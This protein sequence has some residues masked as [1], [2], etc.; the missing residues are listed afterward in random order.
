MRIADSRTVRVAVAFFL[1]LSTSGAVPGGFA[2][3]AAAGSSQ[4]PPSGV[5]AQL[6][7]RAYDILDKQAHRPGADPS[8]IAFQA[9]RLGFDANRIFAFVRDETRIEPYRGML[10]GARGV[11]AGRAGNALDRSLLLQ[12]L[13]TESGIPCRLMQGKLPDATARQALEQF[14]NAPQ[15]QAP[16]APAGDDSDPGATKL[17][18]QAG[19]PD[20]LVAQ[21]RDRCSTHSATFWRSVSSQADE[22]AAYLSGLLSAAGLK[23][24]KADAVQKDLLDALKTHYWV[25]RQDA[26]GN[27]IDL[28]PLLTTLQ[29]GQTAGQDGKPVPNV[30][31]S[32]HHQLDFSLI[33]RT[34]QGNGAKEEVVLKRTVDAADAPFKPMAFAVQSA[35]S[36]LPA[37]F[38]MTNQQKV[39][40]I[41][42][43]KKFQGVFR[44]GSEMTAG[45]PFDL[46][47]NTYDVQPGGVIGNASGVGQATGGAFGGFGGALGGGGAPK[48]PANT[49]LDV[50]VVMT[51]RSPGRQPITQTRVLTT[52]DNPVPPLLNW[53]LF[54]QPGFS[55]D[56]LMEYQFTDYLARQ[57]P[58]IEAILAPKPGGWPVPDNWPFPIYAAS[59][60]MLRNA[61]LR[62]TLGDERG[63]VPLMD[64]PNF[65]ATNHSVRVNAAGTAT[66]GR[67]GVDLVEMGLNF[68]PKAAANESAATNLALRQSVAESTIE[69]V[70]LANAFPATGV[71]SSAARFDLARATGAAIKVIHARDSAALKG[72]NWDD[73]DA[74]GLASAEPSSQL[75]V[76]AAASAGEPPSWWTVAPNGT[77]VARSRGGFGEAET[78]YMELTLNIACKI[79]CFIEMTNAGK[80][81]HQMMSF[82]AC[83]GMQAGGGAAEM[84][85]EEMEF[86]GMGFIV[87]A[88]DLTIWAVMGMTE[89]EE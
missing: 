56:K 51:L 67:W 8:D 58:Y 72:L 2:T 45:R 24:P 3:A 83:A 43:M 25:Q 85:A 48:P 69:Q 61:A 87:S 82:M 53:E 49:F 60:S 38:D 57:R 31:A 75:I 28:D 65:F 64:H 42:R 37:P 70:F 33:Y 12:A 46:N 89:P 77:A 19:V 76:A 86:E 18:Q 63:V 71:T 44:A 73:R 32:L 39:D 9:G 1:V 35:D 50:R 4:S 30:P 84:I 27:W 59:I 80:G 55:P 11:L 79:L 13:L 74:K 47:G 34:K 78:D 54:L 17:L 21:I 7:L 41:R 40:L 68:V 5:S 15:M 36:D 22:R 16:P 52:A 20:P 29:P 81:A 66:E 14:L 10:R 6:V 26:Q 23:P 62:R 88:I